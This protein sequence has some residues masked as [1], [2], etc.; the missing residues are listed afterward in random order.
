MHDG[1]AG[2]DRPASQ[3]RS[4]APRQRESEPPDE[5][6]W[7]AIIH[8]RDRHAYGVLVAR[9]QPSVLAFAQRLARSDHL[10]H[11]ITQEVF[12][13]LWENPERLAPSRGSVRLFLMKDCYGRSIDRI[14]AEGRMRA[15]GQGWA[16]GQDRWSASAEDVALEALQERRLRHL[17]EA[18][19]EPQRDAMLLA[20]VDGLSY[21]GVA[22]TLAVPEG[23]VKSR[24]R[25]GLAALK[26]TIDI[27][28]G[29]QPTM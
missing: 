17:L 23:T 18:L 10:G 2:D 28:E 11:D 14:R 8:E 4:R 13:R 29:G 5:V 25:A 26:S 21:R 15:R 24:I 27:V 1:R 3:R 19:P 16:L 9:Y 7:S 22:A 12:L 20:F 6:L